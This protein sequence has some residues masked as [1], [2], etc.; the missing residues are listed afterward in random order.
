ME[1]LERA[2]LEQRRRKDE[3]RQR[4]AMVHRAHKIEMELWS[5]EAMER[6]RGLRATFGVIV[7]SSTENYT[8]MLR[9]AFRNGPVAR[10]GAPAL[11]RSPCS[12]ITSII[13]VRINYMQI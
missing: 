9:S 7:T 2:Q 13:A 10:L 8:G 1:K 4:S 11:L 12:F 3:S 6:H 5:F